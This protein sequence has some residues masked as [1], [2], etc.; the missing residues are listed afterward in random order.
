MLLSQPNR[1]R[2][3]PPRDSA[4]VA[5]RAQFAQMGRERDSTWAAI[6]AHDTRA[7]CEVVK[8]KGTGHFSFSDAPFQA[9]SLLRDVGATLTPLQSHRL[10]AAKL[11]DFFREKVVRRR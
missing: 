9:P 1:D 6:C 8:L 4:E 11:E 3:A 2:D 7:P 10:I 5:R